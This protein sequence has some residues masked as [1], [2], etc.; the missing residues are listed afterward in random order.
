MFDR[1][2]ERSEGETKK[3]QLS[4]GGTVARRLLG[5]LLVDAKRLRAASVSQVLRCGLKLLWQRLG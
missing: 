5:K 1:S 2:I 3:S 4:L